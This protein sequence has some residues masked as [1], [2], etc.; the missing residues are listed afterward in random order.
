MYCLCSDQSFDNILWKQA[1]SPLPREK[2]IEQYTR[3]NE[4]CGS[5]TEA[6]LREAEN[7]KL[8]LGTGHES[9]V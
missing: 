5:C 8:F 4:G 3:C 9:L 1:N 2:M 6:L 7:L